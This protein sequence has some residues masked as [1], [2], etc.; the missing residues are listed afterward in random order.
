ML[1]LTKLEQPE[2]K[3]TYTF[4]GGEKIEILGVTH[5]AVKTTHRLQTSD[6]KLHIVPS[7]WLHIEIDAPG[8]S[9]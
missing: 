8:F 3:R 4:P 9:V 2:R 6:G 7:G 5:I 1:D